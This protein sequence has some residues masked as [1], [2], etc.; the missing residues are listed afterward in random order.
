MDKFSAETTAPIVLFVYNRPLHTRRTLESLANNRLA[1]RSTLFV[2]AD[3]T[4]EG[5][6]EETLKSIREVREIIKQRKWCKNV[7]LI[8]SEKNKGLAASIRTGVTEI[9]G[10]YNQAIVMEDDLI[11][12][13]AF[14][15]YMNKALVYYQDRK[16]VYSISAY[17]LP[18]GKFSVPADY[19]YDVFVGLRNSSWG[20]ATWKDR[21]NQIDWEVKHYPSLFKNE[22]IRNALNRGGDDVF[23][24]LQ[25]QQEGKLDIWSIQFTMTH[26]V[27]HGVSIIPVESYVNNIGHDGSG[28]NCLH[29]NAL[30]HS[31]LNQKEDIN[32]LNI[33]YED[34]RI[35]NAFYSAYCRH[36]RPIWQK[37]INRLSRNVIGRNFYDLKG[38]VY[39]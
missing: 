36:K 5:A 24:L 39:K 30:S 26:L 25:W 13:P 1:D 2:Y 22:N 33:L 17:C 23:E 37:I 29:S 32:F 34:S 9:I 6:N 3:G 10:K 12:S 18:R 28:E 7:E 20:W 38:K 27:N 4:K 15:T 14:L 31:Y 35:I 19:T 21:W 16:A 11:T 8:E